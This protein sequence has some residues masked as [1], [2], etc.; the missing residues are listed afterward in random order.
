MRLAT[1]FSQN[2]QLLNAQK[3]HPMITRQLAIA[4]GILTV[5]A[6]FL[7]GLPAHA[8][9]ALAHLAAAPG[10]NSVPRSNEAN[11]IDTHPA[12]PRDI[13]LR[14][15]LTIQVRC[16]RRDQRAVEVQGV[17]VTCVHDG[18]HDASPEEGLI[19]GLYRLAMQIPNEVLPGGAA[20]PTLLTA[21][22]TIGVILAGRNVIQVE[23]AGSRANYL[24]NQAIRRKRRTHRH[25]H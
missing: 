10:T 22:R 18:P 5:L 7:A 2:R 13:L 21:Q 9:T 15:L 17:P 1:D 14:S 12:N 24:M 23:L 25:H 19:L 16:T 4:L 20:N 6:A 11:V 8:Q 3:E